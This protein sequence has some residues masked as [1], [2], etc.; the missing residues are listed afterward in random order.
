MIIAGQN[1]LT[2]FWLRETLVQIEDHFFDEVL[3]CVA[4]V[5]L[6]EHGPIVRKTW[7]WSERERESG[8]LKSTREAH[9]SILIQRKEALT[10]FARN[11]LLVG[12]VA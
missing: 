5:A 1:R 9:L 12:P 10:L 11:R 4:L 6:H 8:E 3:D 2:S 7:I